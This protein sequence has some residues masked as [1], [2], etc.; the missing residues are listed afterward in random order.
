MT[1]PCQFAQLI[2]N[3]RGG[4]I[5]EAEFTLAFIGRAIHAPDILANASPDLTEAELTQIIA[6]A[7]AHADK[8][9]FRR[10]SGSSIVDHNQS[11]S[12]RRGSG[13]SGRY[14]VESWTGSRID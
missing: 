1:L 2:R 8:Q 4:R 12:L 9:S 11:A 13:N 14:S 7:E 3:Y 5:N 6:C 10:I